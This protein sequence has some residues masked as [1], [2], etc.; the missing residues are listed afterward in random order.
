[1]KV[2]PPS[3]ARSRTAMAARSSICRPKVIVP[4][5]RRETLRPVRPRR[6]CWMST[7]QDYRARSAVVGV[8]LEVRE[9]MVDVCIPDEEIEPDSR[10]S[11]L[12]HVVF[13]G[14]DFHAVDESLEDVAVDG[15]LDHITVFDCVL[16]ANELL[17]RCE[18]A[19]L[20]VPA[21]DL[22]VALI[23]REASP[24]HLVPGAEM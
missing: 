14:D 8:D 4:R 16:R 7:P 12:E 22:R 18:V 13:G 2:T 23:C 19:H 10:A 20:A 3:A 15:R 9:S 6:V 17:E 24:E 21:H 11:G 5:Q 1:M